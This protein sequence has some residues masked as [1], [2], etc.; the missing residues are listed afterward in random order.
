MVF[1]GKQGTYT[2]NKTIEE[3]DGTKW[4]VKQ[5][6][7][8]TC[9]TGYLK[10]TDPVGQ[11]EYCAKLEWK[12]ND[13]A[14][15]CIEKTR[16]KNYSCQGGKR[17]TEEYQKCISRCGRFGRFG[18]YIERHSCELGCENLQESLYNCNGLSYSQCI[19]NE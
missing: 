5:K 16:P 7:Q 14:K 6:C 9:P 11:V 18:S 12:C 2:P 13:S 17:S 8:L 10:K 3:F 1:P 4:V 19:G 15:S